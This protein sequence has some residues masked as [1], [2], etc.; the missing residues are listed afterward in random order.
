MKK[1]TIILLFICTGLYSQNINYYFQSQQSSDD[2]YVNFDSI[3][4]NQFTQ[5]MAAIKFDDNSIIVVYGD[6]SSHDING[7]I[8]RDF[9][10]IDVRWGSEILLFSHP[11]PDQTNLT[12]I[13][14]LS[15]LFVATFSAG[16]NT[17]KVLISKLGQYSINNGVIYSEPA[18]FPQF[19]EI[20]GIGT[21]KFIMPR[22]ELSPNKTGIVIGD[23]PEGIIS[24]GSIQQQG[25]SPLSQLTE[26]LTD[27]TAVLVV[28][29]TIYLAKISGA[30]I[31]YEAGVYIGSSMFN[32][33]THHQIKKLT[34][35][36][37]V[38]V[39]YNSG[40][41][42][43]IG[44][45]DG[46]TLALGAEYA[47]SATLDN[48]IRSFRVTAILSDTKIVVSYIEDGNN[49]GYV[50]IGDLSGTVITFGSPYLYNNNSSDMSIAG[51]DDS[52]FIVFYVDITDGSIGEYKKATVSGTVITFL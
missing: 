30:S 18:A 52:S 16:S 50:M 7:R 15:D 34:D 6:N 21:F 25:N 26:A 47:V 40:Q 11:A 1:L 5:D 45:I 43:R 29:D 49:D 32:K 51:V 37:F 27:T 42:A 2:F 23:A 46:T 44:T 22:L 9:G 17:E 14:R 31:T 13:T 4:N 8:I 3:F 36:S 38:M 19:H 10:G 41:K 24:F 48:S 33:N 20:S 28:L 35:T 12:Y 39:Y